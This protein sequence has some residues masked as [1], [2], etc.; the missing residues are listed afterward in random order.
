LDPP[1]KHQPLD[2]EVTL[3]VPGRRQFGL[4]ISARTWVMLTFSSAATSAIVRNR[5]ASV[6]SN[7]L[8][9]P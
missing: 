1:L 8:V 2:L 9:R 3:P 5:R 6:T 4:L 7:I